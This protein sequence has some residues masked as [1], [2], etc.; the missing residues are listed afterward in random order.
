[1]GLQILRKLGQKKIQISLG[2]IFKVEKCRESEKIDFSTKIESCCEV[3]DMG[4]GG[5]K[6]CQGEVP[7]D[8]WPPASA[9]APLKKLSN[10]DFFWIRSVHV[11]GIFW[12]PEVGRCRNPVHV[13]S[14]GRSEKRNRHGRVL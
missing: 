5:R 14:A 13:G 9:L 1:M 6:T 4:P 3:R 2:H 11:F 7:Y 12:I 10:F 8:F